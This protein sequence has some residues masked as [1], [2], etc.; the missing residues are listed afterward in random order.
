MDSQKAPL[1]SRPGNCHV[2]QMSWGWAE[3]RAAQ[4]CG[5]LAQIVL[6]S[7]PARQMLNPTGRPSKSLLKTMPAPWTFIFCSAEFLHRKV[8]GTSARKSL[9]SRF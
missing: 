9:K 6:D 8:S 1:T 5:R 7:V 2:A 3:V 4:E